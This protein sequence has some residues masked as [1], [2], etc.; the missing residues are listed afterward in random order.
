MD[1]SAKTKTVITYLPVFVYILLTFLLQAFE[2]GRMTNL[3]VSAF[4]ALFVFG[5]QAAELKNKYGEYE[6]RASLSKYT[7][8]LSSVF[9]IICGN[10]YLHWNKV[11][12]VDFRIAIFFGLTL[13]YLVIIF[14]A[15]HSLNEI[16]TALE[17]TDLQKKKK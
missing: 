15:V 2:V 1:Q 12:H 14:R 7:A 5:V 4:A 13:I 3:L 9:I 16:K 17:K 8:L 10:A 6:G 11:L